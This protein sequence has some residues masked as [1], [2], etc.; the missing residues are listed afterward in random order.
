MEV[1]KNYIESLGHTYVSFIFECIIV[2]IAIGLLVYLAIYHFRSKT[3]TILNID[4]FYPIRLCKKN[5]LLTT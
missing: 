1:L 2:L 5:N 4:I 3:I